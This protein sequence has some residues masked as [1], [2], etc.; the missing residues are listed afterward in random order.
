MR[1]KIES[2]VKFLQTFVSRKW[3]PPFIAFLSALD[4]LILIIPND[5]IL[6]S[7]TLLKPKYWF[8]F[9]VWI[10][11]GSTLGALLLALLVEFQGL[12]WLLN[13]FPELDQSDTW[14]WMSDFFSKYGLLLIFIVALAPIVQQP[15][16][17][18]GALS[19]I[20]LSHL[21]LVL[22]VGRFLKF[23]L[24]TYVAAQA[25]QY[26]NKMWGVQSELKEVGVFEEN[27]DHSA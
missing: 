13:F 27:K 4:N 9:S 11:L 18:M 12:P 5:G 8:R 15:A 20:P 17:V 3:Y 7:S 23:T 24:M 21:C 2:Y 1:E 10:T 25:P 16:V 26:L 22:M 19:E 14:E 6:I